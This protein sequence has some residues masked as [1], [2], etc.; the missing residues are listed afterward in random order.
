MFLAIGV[1]PG[2]AALIVLLAWISLCHIP[3]VEHA[4][5]GAAVA[6]I[7]A[8]EVVGLVLIASVGLAVL[9][10]AAAV[11]RRAY[12]STVTG[13]RPVPSIRRRT[14][15]AKVTIRPSPEQVTPPSASRSWDGVRQDARSFQDV[16]R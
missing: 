10:V 7:T 15:P 16:P 13:D 6:L 11:A 1:A 12:S 3:A 4:F 2:V 5:S 8:V 9:A 14:M